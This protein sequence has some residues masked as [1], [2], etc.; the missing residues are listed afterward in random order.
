MK[1]EEK[2]NER[3][4]TFSEHEQY[5]CKCIL[6]HKKECATTSIEEFA[7]HY[8]ISKSTLSRFA[9]KIGCSGYSELKA[10]I[11]M[12]DQK[13]EKNNDF[14]GNVMKEYHKMV[15]EVIE[16]DCTKL[17]EKIKRA[18]RILI[19]GSGYTQA[20]VASEWKRIFLPTKKIIYDVHGHDMA[21]PLAKMATEEDLV[22]IVSLTG[23]SDGVIALAKELRLQQIPTL[24]ITRMKTNTLAGLCTENLYIHS[25]LLPEHYGVEYEL[26]TPYFILIEL[27]YLKYKQYVLQ[28]TLK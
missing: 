5:V 23:E 19:Y 11:R 14:L 6:K 4:A 2:M 17:F 21:L 24:S 7:K 28:S 16:R 15:D 20:R 25:V 3:Y 8:G 1:L 22:V 26:T 12:E 13:V 9:Q 18:K 10:L 27:L